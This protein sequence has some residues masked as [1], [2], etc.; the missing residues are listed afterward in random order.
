MRVAKLE[1]KSPDRW[2]DPCVYAEESC[3]T[4]DNRLDSRFSY[5]SLPRN[6]KAD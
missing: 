1:K 4:N 6:N 2:I 5:V 3:V